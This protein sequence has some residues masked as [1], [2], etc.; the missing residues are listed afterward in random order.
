MKRFVP[1]AAL[2]V[3]LFCTLTATAVSPA[4]KRVLILGDSISIGYTPVVQKKMSADTIV[5]RPMRG[6]KPENCSDTVSGTQNIDRWLQ[7]DGGH[8]DVI[9]FNWGLHDV[10]HMSD[11]KPSNSES[12]P[13]N[14]TVQAYAKQLGEIVGK[15]KATGAKLVFATTTPVPEGVKPYRNDADVVKYNEAAL[16]IMKENGIAVD[17]LYAFVKAR[18]SEIQRP[19]NVH[20]TE[21]GSEALGEE[22]VKSVRAAL[23]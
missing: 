15:L 12:D 18:Q 1:S 13:P 8:W 4:K 2:S 5:L 19:Q 23:K 22:V 14:S 20:F 11:G 21:A 16:R 10:K 7:I 3:L 17:D 6:D 9:H